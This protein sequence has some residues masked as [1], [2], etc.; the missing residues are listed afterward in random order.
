MAV[1]ALIGAG[2][3]FV[4]NLKSQLTPTP[5][6]TP[7]PG[8][9]TAGPITVNGEMTCLP[10]KGSQQTLECAMGLKGL[11]GRHFGLKN[12][13]QHDPEYKFSVVGLRVE[14][15]G[16]FNPEEMKGPDGNKYNVVGTIDVTSIKEIADGSTQSGTG[17][18]Q[19]EDPE[20]SG[21]AP[22]PDLPL[23]SLP[24]Q[25]LSVKFV[26]EHRSALSGKTILIRGIIVGT[27]IGEKACP[28]DRGACAKPSIF[29]ADTT[30]KN[31]N[32][33]YDLRILVGEEEQEK[34]YPTGK[35]V[36]LQ[37]I[38][39]GSKVSVIAQKMY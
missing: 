32:M 4:L 9:P 15:S 35:T 18:I 29:L 22:Y 39:D 17:T 16:S 38:V 27:L 21:L 36:D 12:L 8:A 30:E 34:S 2:A 19:P 10:K 6:L 33:L 25:P 24:K 7:I 23:T 13:F 31:R 26:V 11:D 28:P 20:R 3:Y 37:V 5:P 14:V 1:V